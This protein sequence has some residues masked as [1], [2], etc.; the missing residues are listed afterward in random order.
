VTASIEIGFLP[1][2]GKRQSSPVPISMTHTNAG[3]GEPVQ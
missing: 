3:V 1:H 2:W